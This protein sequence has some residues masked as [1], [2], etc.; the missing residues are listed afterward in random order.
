MGG[1]DIVRAAAGETVRFEW[2]NYRLDRESFFVSSS[3]HRVVIDGQ[4]RYLVVSRDITERKLL[5]QQLV[6]SEERFRALF[7]QA[8]L[9]YQSLDMGGNI[10]QVNDAWLRLTGRRIARESSDAALRSISMKPLCPPW[11]KLSALCP[12]RPRRGPVFEIRSRRYDAHRDGHR[13]HR[14][15]RAGNPNTPIASLPTSPSAGVPKKRCGRASA[16][17][18]NS[19][20]IPTTPSSFSMPTACNAM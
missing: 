5:E 14:T 10:L 3:V 18:H 17:F 6:E 15:R 8:P 19:S 9:P 11:P 12:V 2:E 1:R 13:A 20:R 4:V 7:E 16:G